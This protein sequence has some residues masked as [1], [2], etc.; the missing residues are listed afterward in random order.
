MSSQL[1]WRHNQIGLDRLIRLRW[2]EKTAYL[3]LAGNDAPAVKTAMQ[4]E[5]KK[6]FSSKNMEKRSSLDKTLTILMKIWV[7]PPH[8]FNHL[9]DDG[10]KLLSYLPSEDHIIVHW[11]MIMAVYPF[12]G[13]VAACVGRL[14]KLQRTVAAGQVQRRIRE[15]YGER[16]TVSRRVRY[17]LRS[18]VDWEVLKETAEKGVYDSGL[19]LNIERPDLIAWLVEAFLLAHHNN[20]VILRTIFNSTSLFPFRFSPI[21]APN[22]VSA[23]ERLE[24]FGQGLDDKLIMLK[25]R[26]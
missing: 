20:S 7:R 16:E 6:V 8:E 19:L 25:N 1:D 21:S 14:L 18:F 24:M 13:A 5:L 22:L 2:L 4:E 15:Q 9:Q 17:V 3:S 10:L 11:G 26:I 23:S 12:W